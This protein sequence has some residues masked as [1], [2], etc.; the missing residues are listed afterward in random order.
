MKRLLA[1]LAVIV[2]VTIV[3]SGCGEPSAHDRYRQMTYR[4]DLDGDVLGIQDD[5]DACFLL[6]R[7][8]HLTNWYNR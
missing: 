7:P 5:I 6:D 4:R 8:T 1:V 3:G 2:S